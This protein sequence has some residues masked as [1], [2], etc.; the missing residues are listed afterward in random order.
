MKNLNLSEINIYPIKSLGGVSLN[1]CLVEERGLQY[2]RRWLLVDKNGMFMTQ[3]TY[4]QMALISVSISKNGLIITHKIN[5]TMRSILIPFNTQ[6]NHTV[7]VIIWSDKCKAVLVGREYNEWFSEAL[8]TECRLVHMPDDEIRLVEKK[9]TSEDR[10][11]SF[12]DAYP[13]LIIGQSSLDDL[14]SRLSVKLPMNR[15]RTN[16]VFT[17]GEPYEEDDWNN[18]TIGVVKFQAVKP[19][20]RCVITTTDQDTSQRNEEPLKTLSTYRKKNNKVLFGMNLI[21]YSYGI[22][23]VGDSIKILD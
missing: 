13:F 1:S 12:A 6:E 7:D 9:Y 4:P 16:F 11:V 3:R 18:F 20:D 17:G 23:N 10:K 21:S 15:F 8:Q 5:R 14:N 2:D 22:I 19:C